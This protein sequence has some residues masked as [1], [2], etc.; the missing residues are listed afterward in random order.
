MLSAAG[1][2]DD[3]SSLRKG[4]PIRKQLCNTVIDLFDQKRPYAFVN[5]GVVAVCRPRI[6]APAA[7]TFPQI[8][9]LEFLPQNRE[10]VDDRKRCDMIPAGAPLE[11]TFLHVVNELALPTRRTSEQKENVERLPKQG[12]IAGVGQA[13]DLFDFSQKRRRRAVCVHSHDLVFPF[14]V[15]ALQV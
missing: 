13:E 2:L 8:I 4:S 5:N 11:G 12:F 6:E 7:K 9:L 14:D 1:K 3:E 15:P 10:V